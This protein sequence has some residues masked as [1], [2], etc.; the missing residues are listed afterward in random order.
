MTEPTETFA[1][2]TFIIAEALCVEE[3]GEPIKPLVCH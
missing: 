2:H 3:T 1:E